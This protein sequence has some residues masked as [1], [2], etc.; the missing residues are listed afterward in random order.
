MKV[1]LDEFKVLQDAV[2]EGDYKEQYIPLYAEFSDFC[3]TDFS[4]PEY[5]KLLE[6]LV[7][8]KVV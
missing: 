1:S 7:K 8:I 3:E 2:Y 5:I 4:N 6:G